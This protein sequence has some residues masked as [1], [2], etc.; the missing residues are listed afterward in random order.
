[1]VQAGAIL[2]DDYNTEA[3]LDNVFK[4]APRSTSI[5]SECRSQLMA[6]STLMRSKTQ[7]ED[8]V[9]LEFV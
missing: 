8:D 6:V 3:I 2:E 9:I 5:L 1:M 7:K 4:G